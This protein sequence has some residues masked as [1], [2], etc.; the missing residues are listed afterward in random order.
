[1]LQNYKV[2]ST[3]THSLTLTS[4]LNT[5]NQHRR[6]RRP[7]PL[8]T[9]VVGT[10]IW[11]TIV[12][13]KD[14]ICHQCGKQ[15]NIQRVCRSK[16]QSKPKQA[17][18]TPEVHAVEVE[19]DVDVD[20]YEDI[21]A[22]FEVHLRGTP[23]RKQSNDIIWV[24]LDVD[25]KPLKMELDTGSAVSTISFDLYQQKFNR[26]PLHK[27]GLSLKTYTGE[28]I[29]PVGE[30][31]VP[32]DYQNQREVLDLYVVK[33]KGSV[34]MGRDWLHTIRFDWCSIKSLQAS[35]A[36]SSPKER[37]DVMLDQ[38]SDVFEN[39]LGNFTTA[40]AKLTL[41]DDSQAGFLN[42]SPMLYAL[43]PKVEEELRRLQKERILTKVEWS[44]W[45]TPIVPVPKKDGSVRLCG[46]YK[47]TVNLELQVEQYPLPRIED[48]FANLAGGQKFS[49]IDL[50]QA[51]HQ[52]EM[53]EDSKKYTLMGLFQYNRLV[54][55]ITSAPAIWQ[56]TIDQVLEGT[57][58]TS[59]ILDDMI[60]TGK[61]DDEHLASLEEV[62][63][64]LQAHGLL[65]LIHIWRC[66]R[67]G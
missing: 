55:G 5:K 59:C 45:A 33:N 41:K 8:A 58:G 47:I 30:L 3:P 35:L 11:H 23:S 42:T 14:Q 19:V 66:R 1:M 40:K 34:L 65:S 31:K 27:T 60:I 37:L 22:T 38:Y 53:E 17:T 64:R 4:W 39:K 18:K 10:H 46:D 26:L 44:E 57:S 52:I 12:F 25:G 50:R 36:T 29:M 21:L 48:I 9:A 13:T 63:R 51:Y 6:N 7:P 15:G 56:R 20:A 32:V 54:F 61:N 43:K 28:N 67:R 16:Q 49:K 24:N 62:L 2:S